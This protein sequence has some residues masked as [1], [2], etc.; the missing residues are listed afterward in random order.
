MI[1]L[2]KTR[3]TLPKEQVQTGA[4][5]DVDN[6]LVPGRSIEERFF[7]HLWS[8]GHI[9][10][11][12]LTRCVVHLFRHMPPISRQPLR[13]YKAYLK[14]KRSSTIEP[15]ATSFVEREIYPRLSSDGRAA[16][17]KHQR[18]RHYTVLVTA[19]LDFLVLPIAGVLGVD[20]VL[21]ARPEQVDGQYTGRLLSPFPYGE[22][23][24]HV[25]EKFA[26]EQG[27][28]LKDC[29][30]YGDSPGDRYILGAVGYPLVVN[31]IR[32]MG[33]FAKRK[34]WPVTRWR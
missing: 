4:F 33:A 12:E 3:S 25:V 20:A 7:F 18:Q 16:I 21:A 10:V 26:R 5:F 11:E 6:T 27:L 1:H 13:E 24:R 22:G 8:Q 32:G 19:S 28:D 34:G 31:P 23:K 14:G 30:A 2:P 17:E 29:Y 9:G 15:L